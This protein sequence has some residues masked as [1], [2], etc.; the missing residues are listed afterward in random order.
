MNI[1]EVAKDEPSA[2]I[3]IPIDV[4]KGIQREQA[5]EMAQK[6]GFAKQ[7]IDQAVEIF[8]HL[9]DMFI[10][11]DCNL[12]EINPLAEDVNGK[13]NRASI[14]FQLLLISAIFN[15]SI[16]LYLLQSLYQSFFF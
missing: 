6:M 13:G 3:T 7:C 1:E 12:L 10:A 11:C 14:F 4:S 2:I 15:R 16:S 5:I 8:M 9:Y